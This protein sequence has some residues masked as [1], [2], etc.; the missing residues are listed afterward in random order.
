M[1][2]VLIV[3]D[4]KNI[5]S[6]LQKTLQLEG[7]DVTTAATGPE[8]LDLIKNNHFHLI[9][10]DIKLPEMSGTEVLKRMRADNINTPV[11]IITAYPTVKN[12]V[13]CIQLGAITYLQ[14]PFTAERL[15]GVL[16]QFNLYENDDD[17]SNT[18]LPCDLINSALDQQQYE[19]ALKLLHSSLAIAPT[20]PHVYRLMAKAYRGL[21]DEMHAIKFEEVSKIFRM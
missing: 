6:L 2:K 1:K 16:Q 21:G 13:D 12:A 17:T 7:Y 19:K 5:R 20:N 3:D 4:T 9:F 18:E 14:K 8:G 11:V 15:K 10:L